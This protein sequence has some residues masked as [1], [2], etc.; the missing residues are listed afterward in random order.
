[1]LEAYFLYHLSYKEVWTQ[2]P[3]SNHGEPH[4]SPC[5]SRQGELFYREE[6][7]VERAVVSKNL[8]AVQETWV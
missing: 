6:K 4:Q 1:M 3:F 5:K 7:K 2:I 8:P